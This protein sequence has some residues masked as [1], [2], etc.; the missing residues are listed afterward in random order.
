MAVSLGA[1]VLGGW[2]LFS[3]LPMTPPRE[4]KVVLIFGT[5]RGNPEVVL[6]GGGVLILGPVLIFWAGVYSM[7]LPHSSQIVNSPGRPSRQQIGPGE[8]PCT[9]RCFQLLPEGGHDYVLPTATIL[10]NRCS[11]LPPMFLPCHS[12]QQTTDTNNMAM[13]WST[14]CAC[15]PYSGAAKH[16]QTTGCRTGGG[17][18]R[19]FCRPW[20]SPNSNTC[21]TLPTPLNFARGKCRDL[22]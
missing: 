13:L 3:F 14:P 5:L 18:G 11:A 16:I 2:F 22:P 15:G 1:L 21:T 4:S 7:A 6:W 20:E 10:S 9:A 12:P 17:G 19:G 8:C